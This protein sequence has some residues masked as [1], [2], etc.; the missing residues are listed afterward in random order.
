MKKCE[1]FDRKDFDIRRISFCQ[2][3]VVGRITDGNG[4]VVDC[5]KSHAQKEELLIFEYI[6]IKSVYRGCCQLR[7]EITEKDFGT[8]AERRETVR[9]SVF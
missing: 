1:N 2:K 7:G 5:V 8:R 4:G 3:N 6:I 9:R